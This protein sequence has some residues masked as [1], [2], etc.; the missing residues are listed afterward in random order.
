MMDAGLRGQ[1]D[2]GEVQSCSEWLGS[3]ARCSGGSSGSGGLDFGGE[4]EPSSRREE[5]IAVTGRINWE[6]GPE[7]RARLAAQGEA[8]RA[9]LRAAGLTGAHGPAGE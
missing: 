6:S 8:L 3:E 7:A 2:P 9:L 4:V 1:A 5:N